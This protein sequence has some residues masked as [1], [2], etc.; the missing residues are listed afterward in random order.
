MIEKICAQC[1]LSFRAPK[2]RSKHCS[3]VCQ[4]QAARTGAGY[5]Q[6][7]AGME[8][9]VVMERHL[10]RKLSTHEHVHHKNENKRDNRLENLE[11]LTVQEHTSLHRLIFPKTKTCEAC[12]NLYM[13]HRQKRRTS[14]TCSK[15]CRYALMTQTMRSKAS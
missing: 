3:K 5:V 9:R 4:H 15:V 11:V 8:H 13:P 1:G 14:K 6:T 2:A 12:G 10:G 7:D